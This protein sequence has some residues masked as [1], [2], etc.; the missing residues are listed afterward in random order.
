M[1]SEAPPATPAPARGGRPLIYIC[2]I[3]P[4]AD[5]NGHV[6]YVRAHALAASALGFSPQIFCVAALGCTNAE[7]GV[8]P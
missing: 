4:T 3:D 7:L 5:A 2:G 8:T 1:S 6:T